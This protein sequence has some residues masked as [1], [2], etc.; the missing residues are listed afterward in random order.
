MDNSKKKILNRITE[1]YKKC[2]SFNL[3]YPLIERV[4][5]FEENNLFKFILN[6][7]K[8]VKEYLDIPTKLTI[9]SQLPIEHKLKGEEK[10]IKICKVKNATSYINPIGGVNLY[11]KSNFKKQNID[12]RFL[13]SNDIIY[14][15]FENE[16]IPFLSI[17]DVMMFN[18]REDT[19]VLLTEF[20]LQ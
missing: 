4:I 9:S 15:Q 19:K 3:V 16:F 18:S 6:S 17:V 2:N 11:S 10:V 8:E 14:S 13:R 20:V 12:L 7:I 5:L 1:S